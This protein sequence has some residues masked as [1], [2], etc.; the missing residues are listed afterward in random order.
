MAKEIDDETFRIGIEWF[1]RERESVEK[2]CRKMVRRA[3]YDLREQLYELAIDEAQRT[4]PMAMLTYHAN[5]ASLKTHILVAIRWYVWKKLISNLRDGVIEY[6]DEF[7]TRDYYNEEG[8]R[9]HF[10]E[11]LQAHE[12]A[13]QQNGHAEFLAADVVQYL[14][15]VMN[16]EQFMLLE[17]YYIDEL[18]ID[19]IADLLGCSKTTAWRYLQDAIGAAKQHGQG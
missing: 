5:G 18:T 4:I 1:M 19:E 8:K 3:P 7:D 15:R 12:E 17:W 10:K 2:L 6:H 14:C 13:S 16:V 11:S 9:R